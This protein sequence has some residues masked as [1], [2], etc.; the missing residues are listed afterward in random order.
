MAPVRTKQKTFPTED[1]SVLKHRQQ[2]KGQGSNALP[3]V[4]KIKASIRQTKRLLSKASPFNSKH[5]NLAADVR[6]E[7]ERRLKSLE[8]DLQRVELAKKERQ[9][10][11]RYH[12]VKFFERQKVV[13]K[14]NQTKKRM[15]SSEIKSA[16][17]ELRVDLNYILHY[18]KTKKYISLFP[19]EA[20]KGE[21]RP[22]AEES[23]NSNAQKEEIRS[24]IREK[25]VVGE[26]P[27]KPEETKSQNVT[28]AMPHPQQPGKAKS[29]AENNRGTSATKPTDDVGQDPFFGDDGDEESDESSD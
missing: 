1:N 27:A 11:V 22:T 12:K 29:K 19:P 13:R 5:D 18:P 3:G 28:V 17:S 15:G 9:F 16:L 23:A 8:S 26:L 6:V 4:Q 14:I 25:M 21:T 20:R 10:A 7:T 24:W 2:R